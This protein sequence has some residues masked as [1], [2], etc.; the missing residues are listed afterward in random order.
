MSIRSVTAAGLAD[1]LGAP[2]LVPVDVRDVNAYNGWRLAGE[3]RGGHLPGARS[4][5]AQWMG[6][7]FWEDVLRKKALPSAADMAV[8]GYDDGRAERVAR[9]LAGRRTGQTLLCRQFLEEWV[10]DESLPLVR[11]PRFSALVHPGWVRD[12]LADMDVEEPPEESLVVCHSHYRN[13]DDYARGH[14]PGA[15][16]MNTLALEEPRMWN[17]RSPDELRE[18]LL[19]HGITADTT[20]VTYGRYSGPDNRDPFPGSNAG[21]IGAI[22]SAVIMMYAGVR[23][24]RVLNGGLMAWEAA[25]LP[26]SQ[27]AA[28]PRPAVEFGAEIP[29]RPELMADLPEARKLLAADDGELVSVRSWREF[30]G[31]VSGYNYIDVKGRIPG[32]VFG[33]CGSDAYH[34][35]NFRNP[36]HTTREYGEVERRWLDAGISPEKRIAFYCGTGWRASEA[37]LNAWLLGWNDIAV[38]DGGWMEWSSDSSNPVETGVPGDGNG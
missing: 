36:D 34:M 10:T 9:A 18:A 29:A 28:Q 35:E 1:R 37:F 33:D 7:E 26:V 17:R 11:M 14:I 25:G 20:V 31:E 24:V 32:A 16:A 6:E 27:E 15:V 4:L 3:K 2:G 22:R 23:D 13:P 12:A 38:F 21:H 30:I 19:A 8:Y 5:P